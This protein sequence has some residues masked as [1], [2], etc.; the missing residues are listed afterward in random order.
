MIERAKKARPT[1][2]LLLIA[3]ML[4]QGGLLL[5]TTSIGFLLAR[6]LGLPAGFAVA[7]VAM[8]ATSLLLAW[9]VVEKVRGMIR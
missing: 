6:W 5:V 7:G 1:V 3:L 9:L 2:R 4:A 8:I